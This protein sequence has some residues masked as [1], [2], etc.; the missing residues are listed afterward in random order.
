MG[1]FIYR[2]NDFQDWISLIFFVNLICIYGMFLLD[3]LRLKRLIRFYATDLY[4]SKHISEKNLN[5]L[6]PFNLLSFLIILNTLSLLFL[7]IS[8]YLDVFVEFAF[9]FY[10]ILLNLIIFFSLRFY[11]LKFIFKQLNLDRDLNIFFFK[12]FAYNTQFSLIILVFLF[13]NFYSSSLNSQFIRVL[14]FPL[15]LWFLYQ[16]KIIISLFRSNPRDILYIILYLC[17]LKIIPWYW[18]YFFAIESKL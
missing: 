9:E 12:S 18:F 13:C 16:S 17:T 7:S 15:G 8:N 5:Y 3:P 11:L 4:V 6:S 1:E 10:Y 14:I 2:N